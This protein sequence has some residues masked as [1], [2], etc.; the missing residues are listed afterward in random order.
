MT[1]LYEEL[2][3]SKTASP[4]DVKAAY[5]VAAQRSH[6]DK[7]GGDEEKFKR[8]GE[9]FAVL[10]NPERRAEYD[11]TG[12]TKEGMTVEAEAAQML[13]TLFD[14]Y[15]TGSS[16]QDPLTFMREHIDVADKQ[17]RAQMDTA[18]KLGKRLAKLQT[19]LKV[20]GLL[21]EVLAFRASACKAD[22]VSLARGE[23]VVIAMYAMMEN[24]EYVLDEEDK[25]SAGYSGLQRAIMGAAYDGR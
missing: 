14:S 15:L 5:R 13:R 6:P 20:P 9:A 2:G 16:R 7:E 24:A 21:T 19:Q 25:M 12:S 11:R 8:V 22:Q 4:E 10:S 23:L 18:I 1:D 17:R 3:V